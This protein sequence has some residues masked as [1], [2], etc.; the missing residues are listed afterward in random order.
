MLDGESFTSFCTARVYYFATGLGR[1]S[2]PKSMGS[3]S[4]NYAWLVC[5]FHASQSSVTGGGDSSEVK[6]KVSICKIYIEDFVVV[7]NDR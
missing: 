2:V 7:V 4:F 3:L 1:H 5:S 6:Q